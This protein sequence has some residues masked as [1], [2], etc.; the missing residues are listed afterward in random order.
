MESGQRP[1]Q[2]P[3]PGWYPNPGGSGEQYWDGTTWID[4]Y[5]A[6]TV[7]HPEPVPP[8]LPPAGWYPNPEGYGQRYWDGTTWTDQVYVPTDEPAGRGDEPAGRGTIPRNLLI[9]I[10]A[11]LL[12]G[13]GIA[14]GVMIGSE[15]NG[16]S[17]DQAAAPS[18]DPY[19]PPDTSGSEVEP[20]DTGPP[21]C[22]ELARQGRTGICVGKDPGDEFK[23]AFLDQTLHLETLDARVDGITTAETTGPPYLRERASGIFLTIALAIT[24]QTSSPKDLSFKDQIAVLEVNGNSYTQDFDA[25]NQSDQ[26]SFISQSE[27]IQPGITQVG[28]VI[29][30]V[31]PEIA[32]NVLRDDTNAAILI[33]EFGRVRRTNPVG[34]IVLREQGP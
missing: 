32:E 1:P 27:P 12:I 18:P 19:T 29:Y 23:I 17:E 15:S 10:A 26:R 8:Q 6:A 4:Q 30:D 16:G 28:H 9:G 13:G 5:R 31:P 2:Q 25:E 7:E 22:L 3:P 20:V 14:V 24:N 11:L 33:P 21:R 34:G